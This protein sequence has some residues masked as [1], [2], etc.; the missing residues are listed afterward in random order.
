MSVLKNANLISMAKS[1]TESDRNLNAK[2]VAVNDIGSVE[3]SEEKVQSNYC[4]FEARKCDY[5]MEKVNFPK[6]SLIYVN[7]AYLAKQKH[8]KIYYCDYYILGKIVEA[9]NPPQNIDSYEL[10]KKEVKMVRLK[11]N[12]E[13]IDFIGLY[14]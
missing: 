14:V 13:T 9:S 1:A 4:L 6:N 11:N 3:V 2:I 8:K 12:S 5:N 7:Q 10:K